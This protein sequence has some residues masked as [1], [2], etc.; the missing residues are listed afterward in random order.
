[1]FSQDAVRLH[2][3]HTGLA[4]PSPPPTPPDTHAPDQGQDQE[5]HQ[6][7]DSQTGPNP[8][9]PATP[10]RAAEARWSSPSTGTRQGPSETASETTAGAGK[11][12]ST[13]PASQSSSPSS[14]CPS[15][16]PGGGDACGGSG[17]GSGVYM[18]FRVEGIKCEGCAARLKTAL[19]GAL[20]SRGL[21]RCAVDFGSGTV[22]VWGA[23]GGELSE[24]EVRAAIQFVDLSY[25]VTLVESRGL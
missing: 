13:T 14:T 21:Q 6:Q 2:N 1:M 11:A 18:R 19:L 12:G 24:A 17:S 16:G 10:D 5:W 20:G 23:P 8:H 7:D 3:L 15:S 9:R 25:R 4:P 22:L